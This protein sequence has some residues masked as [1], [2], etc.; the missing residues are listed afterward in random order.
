MEEILKHLIATVCGIL[1]LCCILRQRRY[2]RELQENRPS[3]SIRA[4]YRISIF[5]TLSTFALCIFMQSEW[6]WEIFVSILLLALVFCVKIT[7]SPSVIG[8]TLAMCV[9]RIYQFDDF[10]LIE[11]WLSLTTVLTWRLPEEIR[12]AYACISFIWILVAALSSPASGE[13]GAQN[14]LEGVGEGL[15]SLHA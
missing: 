10:P 12:A 14:A 11:V 4:G 5:V 3:G 2:W 6:M 1:I 7:F 13:Q 8:L 9:Y 15:S